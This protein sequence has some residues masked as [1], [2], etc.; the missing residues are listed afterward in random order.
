MTKSPF[1]KY[2]LPIVYA[3]QQQ[4]LILK[5][6]PHL[7][8]VVTLFK[9]LGV[10][11]PRDTE[12]RL[13]LPSTPSRAADAL[14]TRRVESRAPVDVHVLAVSAVRMRSESRAHLVARFSGDSP[15]L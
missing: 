3:S 5:Q 9:R 12:L 15:T 7:V 11:T 4:T 13:L 14:G 10:L 8:G 2:Y 6:L 1:I